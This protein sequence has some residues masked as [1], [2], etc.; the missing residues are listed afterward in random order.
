MSCK[1]GRIIAKIGSINMVTMIAPKPPTETI[2]ITSF[3]LPCK[4]ILCPGSIEVAVPS[5]GTPKSIEGTNSISAWAIDIATIVTQMNSGDK[6]VNRKVEDANIIAPAV[7]TCIPGII[8]VI[9]PINIPIKQAITNSIIPINYSNFNLYFVEVITHYCF[10]LVK[11][12]LYDKIVFIYKY[13][14]DF[15]KLL[16]FKK[17]LCV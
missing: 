10:S 13:C 16:S 1:T 2:L 15:V 17:Y 7:L 6:N 3:D 4:T 5:C 12:K 9:V 14:R 8:P 11:L